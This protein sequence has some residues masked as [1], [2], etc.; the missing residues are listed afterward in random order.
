VPCRVRAVMISATT[1]ALMAGCGGP[2]A[3]EAEQYLRD[4]LRSDRRI[5]DVSCEGGD[6]IF[7]C[8]AVVNGRKMSYSIEQD[9]SG[10]FARLP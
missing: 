10:E 2:S 6:T 3:D 4:S 8:T 9:D 7:T 1:L 5:A